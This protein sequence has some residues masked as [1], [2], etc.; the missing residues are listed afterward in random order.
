MSNLEDRKSNIVIDADAEQPADRTQRALDS[1]ARQKMRQ[2][3][4]GAMIGM[5]FSG[6]GDSLSNRWVANAVRVIPVIYAGAFFMLCFYAFARS[7]A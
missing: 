1:I 7:L 6:L 4:D 2:E 5:V 3:R